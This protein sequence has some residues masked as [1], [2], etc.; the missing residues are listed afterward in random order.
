MPPRFDDGAGAGASLF[1]EATSTAGTFGRFVPRALAGLPRL[2]AA[3]DRPSGIG[4][5]P[6]PLGGP[7][8]EVVF[9]S[10]SA[11]DERDPAPE[12]LCVPPSG[13]FFPP[14]PTR[15]DCIATDAAGNTSHASFEVF[16]D[17]RIR[18]R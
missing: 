1:A 6:R 10:V 17:R 13:S 18:P 2:L 3:D 7:A 12:L 16:V 5:R 8:G 9:F 14:G 15:V 11:S 4:A